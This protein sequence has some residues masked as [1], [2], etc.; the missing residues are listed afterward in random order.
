MDTH[1]LRWYIYKEPIYRWFRVDGKLLKPNADTLTQHS[2]SKDILHEQ[3]NSAQLF[4]KRK[5]MLY[6]LWNTT[7]LLLIEFYFKWQVRNI[8]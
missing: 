7:S 3:T 8:N 1:T 2:D 6:Q 5:S 4:H